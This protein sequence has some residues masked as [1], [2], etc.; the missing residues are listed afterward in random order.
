MH[1][2]LRLTVSRDISVAISWDNHKNKQNET[3]A[4]VTSSNA[5]PADGHSPG[6]PFPQ[7]K[8]GG[9][10]LG[11]GCSKFFTENKERWPASRFPDEWLSFSALWST[12]PALEAGLTGSDERGRA[13]ASSAVTGDLQ[14]LRA[15]TLYVSMSL[16]EI[17]GAGQA[18]RR[19]HHLETSGVSLRARPQHHP[20]PA[21][22]PHLQRGW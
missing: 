20:L 16:A 17:S 7:D 15:P 1:L 11:I 3:K 2:H 10:A 22:C 14:A 21:H 13:R 8:K 18:S 5:L 6:L 4:V 12:L 19:V 9:W